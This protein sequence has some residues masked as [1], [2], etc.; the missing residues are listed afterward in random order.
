MIMVNDIPSWWSNYKYFDWQE[1]KCPCCGR[2]DMAEGFIAWLNQLR[3]VVN[4]PFVI[5]SGYRCK[6]HNAKVGGAIDSAH[7][8]G[9][10][11]DIHVPD[12]EFRYRIIDMAIRLGVRGI[13]VGKNF[14]HLDL[15]YRKPY[16]RMWWYA[17]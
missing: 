6:N 17:K 7:L 16:P 12:N 9:L 13:G 3:A 4:A 2:C 10:A 11:A 1:F 8:A 14:V 15:D 5:T